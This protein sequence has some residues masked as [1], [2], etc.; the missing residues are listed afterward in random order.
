MTI[1][2]YHVT[3]DFNRACRHVAF[4]VPAGVTQI[5]GENESGKTSALEAMMRVF[6]GL[7]GFAPFRKPQ[8][9]WNELR[10]GA[11]FDLGE[12]DAE[13]ILT[14]ANNDKGGV[15]KVTRKDG[16]P[17]KAE[18]LHELFGEHSHDPNELARASEDE[19][20]RVLQQLSGPEFVERQNQLGA[21]YDQAYAER[22]AAKK[23]LGGF[24]TQPNPG[25]EPEAINVDDALAAMKEA[26]AF[27]DEQ[28]RRV[29]ALE[30][31]SDAVHAA[32]AIA[33]K[34]HYRVE[35]LRAALTSAETEAANARG[36]V[37]QANAALSL[38]VQP[39][40]FLNVTPLQ[41]RIAEAGARNREREQWRA[42][43]DRWTRW[44]DAV[45]LA[46]DLERKVAALADEKEK[47]ARSVKL[48]VEGIGWNKGQV[49]IDGRPWREEST[50]KL[51]R[52]CTRLILA[53]QAAE[54]KLKLIFV[55]RGESLD[56]KSFAA[57][58][59]EVNAVPDAVL[60]MEKVGEPLDGG[61]A[62]IRMVDGVGIGDDEPV[63]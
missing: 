31:A 43:Q 26:Q 7:K 14:E 51:M 25:D 54:G 49:T 6:R 40:T 2:L 36:R 24:G 53:A 21:D 59:E 55:H 48:P 20:I 22:A 39:E 3:V 8:L 11:K 35:E 5:A 1:R 45:R 47:H 9:T 32:T 23:V 46:N 27:N 58:C 52:I 42:A 29:R 18:V 57:L 16:T 15:V 34:A 17:L 13:L 44:Q 63:F 4:S 28:Q 62:V 61:A 33:D 10:G 12:L 19:V 60:L 56:K 41:Q 50:S 37:D 38:L 30:R